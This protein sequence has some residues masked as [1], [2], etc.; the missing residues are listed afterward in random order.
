MRKRRLLTEPGPGAAQ[1]GNLYRE[2]TDDEAILPLPQ[3]SGRI[4]NEIHPTR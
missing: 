2:T 1:L 3:T 4:C